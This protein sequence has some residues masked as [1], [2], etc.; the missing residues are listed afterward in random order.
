MNKQWVVVQD[1]SGN[2]IVYRDDSA[3]LSV[4][5]QFVVEGEGLFSTLQALGDSVYNAKP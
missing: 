2:L 3:T 1:S 4:S 5:K